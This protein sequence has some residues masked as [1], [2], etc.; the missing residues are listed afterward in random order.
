MEQNEPKEK[1]GLGFYIGVIKIPLVIMIVWSLTVMIVVLMLPQQQAMIVSLVSWLGIILIDGWTG[2]LVTRK[3]TDGE[4]GVGARSGA[5]LG[6]IS[7]LVLALV[8]II[9]FFGFPAIFTPMIEKSMQTVE[10]MGQ[11]ITK[12]QML[13]GMQIGYISGIIINPLLYGLAGALFSGVAALI[14]RKK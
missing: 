4:G 7:G 9:L 6:V 3:V 5:V 12:E 10:D 14:F 13:L 2:F 8:G 1:K 11:S